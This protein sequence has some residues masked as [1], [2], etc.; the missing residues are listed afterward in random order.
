M[1]ATNIRVAHVLGSLIHGGVQTTALRLIRGLERQTLSQVVLYEFANDGDMRREFEEAVE[2]RHCPYRRGHRLE[3]ARR[4]AGALKEERA[5]VVLCHAFGNHALVGLAAKLAGVPRTY[6]LVTM[7]PASLRRGWWRTYALVQGARLFCDS[8][9]AV[10]E[11]VGKSLVEQ[12]HL[13]SRRVIVI[14]NG[15]D[16]TEVERR[17]VE[18]R[19]RAPREGWR[20]LMVSRMSEPKDHTTLLAAVAL[21]RA[22]GRPAELFL[23]GDGRRRG[24][25][26]AAA[27]R[28]GIEECTHFLGTRADV[29]ELL[30]SSDVSV[31][32]T[33]SE[34]LGIALLESMAAGTPVVATDVPSCREVL[35]GGK[36]GVLFP[37]RDAAALARELETVL[38]DA[39]Y[40]EQL[41]RAARLRVREH[42]DLGLMAERYGRL[43]RGS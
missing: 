29:P 10:S 19:R 41:T 1:A 33:E 42:Y 23:A 18:A 9:I 13:P 6:A 24:E 26:E 15:C 4:L 5:D 43:L 25:H 34:G 21:L 38:G 16:V 36:C 12:L 27:R 17:A 11:S 30:G 22:K 7:E 8:E 28:L 40:R 3:F 39:A 37:R 2:V 14:P 35:D 20:I 32:S 31:L